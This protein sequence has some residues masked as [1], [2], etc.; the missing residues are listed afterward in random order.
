AADAAA[1]VLTPGQQAPLGGT[2]SLPRRLQLL[3][4]AA[5]PGA[6]IIE[7]DYLSELRLEG[8]AAPALASLDRAGR[9]IHI[10]SFSKT[11]SPTLRL[12]FVVAP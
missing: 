3:D 12:G 1:A 10:G 11:I 8:R 5:A 4:W 7:D 9:V 2:L 6:W